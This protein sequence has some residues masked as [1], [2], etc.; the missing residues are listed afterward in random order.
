[1]NVPPPAPIALATPRLELR[2]FD[3]QDDA[4]VVLRLLNEPSFIE[5]IGD[6]GVR[7]LDDARRYLREGPIA[8]CRSHGHGLLRVSL[9][10]DGTVIGMCGLVRRDT[11][12]VPDLGFALLPEHQGK[13]YVQEASRAALAHGRSALGLT[14]VLAITTT[15]NQRSMATLRMLGMTLE[16]T[17][18]L[19]AGAPP[20]NVFR[21]RLTPD[22]AAPGAAPATDPSMG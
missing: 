9:R 15:H 3:E 10:D 20:V 5:F 19:T 21:L 17:R 2:E 7:T 4:P 14:E 12:P 16:D 13:G 18:A 8:S 6:R 11:L 1:V 22:A